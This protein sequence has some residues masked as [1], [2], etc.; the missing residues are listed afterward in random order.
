MF[1]VNFNFH[2]RRG[3]HN[4]KR[5]HADVATQVVFSL[6]TEQFQTRNSKFIVHPQVAA[7]GLCYSRQVKQLT[8]TVQPPVTSREQ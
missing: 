7:G 3:I 8:G 6:R 2:K 1:V 4:G 5:V